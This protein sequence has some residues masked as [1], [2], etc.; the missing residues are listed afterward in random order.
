MGKV[1]V[2]P[3]T[4]EHT[5]LGNI[6]TAPAATLTQK[7]EQFLRLRQRQQTVEQS[8]TVFEPSPAQ[9]RMNRLAAEMLDVRIDRAVQDLTQLPEDSYEARANMQTLFTLADSQPEATDVLEEAALYVTSAYWNAGLVSTD[10]VAPLLRYRAMAAEQRHRDTDGLPL[11]VDAIHAVVTDYVVGC[12]TDER[13]Q[14]MHQIEEHGL[15]PFFDHPD[16]DP[17]FPP[18]A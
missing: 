18:V 3:G 7:A 12:Y 9:R 16:N 6:E 4:H 10:D 5:A 11:A 17:G 2:F 14:R 15:L 8:L 1:I 13:L